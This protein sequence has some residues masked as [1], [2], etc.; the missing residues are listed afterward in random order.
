MATSS[1]GSEFELTTAP[2]G[3]VVQSCDLRQ[4][5]RLGDTDNDSLLADLEKMAVERVESDTQRQLVSATWKMFL[6]CFPSVITIRKNPVSAI[7]QI[8]YVDVDGDW[9]TLSTSVYDTFLQREPAE[10]RLA[11]SQSWPLTRQTEQAVEVTFVAGYGSADDVPEI[12][13]H[14]VKLIVAGEYHGCDDNETAIKSL[15]SRLNWGI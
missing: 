2:A 1:L 14:A 15:L 8:R 12:A 4:Y 5:V 10:I 9:Q 6:P 13:K 3:A 11:Y 7:S